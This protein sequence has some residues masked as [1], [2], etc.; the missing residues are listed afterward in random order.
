MRLFSLSLLN[1]D[2][3]PMQKD[4]KELKERLIERI[5]TLDVDNLENV[6]SFI[7]N[8][9]TEKRSVGDVLSFAGAWHD[10]DDEVFLDLTKNL[11]TNRQEGNSRINE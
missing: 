1:Y 11:S 9:T 2:S 6:E 7:S 3:F 8:L 4:T 10:L 5:H